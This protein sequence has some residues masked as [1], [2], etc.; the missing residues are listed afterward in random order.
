MD[1]AAMEVMEVYRRIWAITITITMGNEI[2]AMA[3][4]GTRINMVLCHHQGI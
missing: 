1:M 3:I 4:I 2:R